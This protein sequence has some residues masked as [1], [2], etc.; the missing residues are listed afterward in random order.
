MCQAMVM[1]AEQDQV[2]LVRLAAVGPVDDVVSLEEASE[3]T[4][5][6]AAATVSGLDGA[7]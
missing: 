4:A 2:R 1:A 3:L 6:I 7:A 5:W